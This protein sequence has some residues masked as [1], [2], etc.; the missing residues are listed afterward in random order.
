MLRLARAVHRDLPDDTGLVVAA[1]RAPP[2]PFVPE[3]LRGAPGF[4]VLRHA[5]IAPGA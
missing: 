4:V 3:H 2:A 5:D 1:V